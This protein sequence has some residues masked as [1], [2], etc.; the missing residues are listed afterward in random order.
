ML[1]QK[2]NEIQI[3]GL[4]FF[5]I[6]LKQSKDNTHIKSFFR[7]NSILQDHSKTI[8]F[9]QDLAFEMFLECFYEIHETF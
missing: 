7:G 5:L 9:L 6:C 2:N 8:T 3:L 4:I 1:A